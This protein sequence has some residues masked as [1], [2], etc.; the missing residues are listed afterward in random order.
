MERSERIDLHSV[1]PYSY[2][3]I[4]QYNHSTIPGNLKSPAYHTIAGLFCKIFL[5][6]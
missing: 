1:E 5:E 6:E 2:S 3:T 4:P